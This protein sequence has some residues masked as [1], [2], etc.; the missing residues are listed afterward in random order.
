MLRGALVV[1]A[2]RNCAGPV[3]WFGGPGR[4]PLRCESCRVEKARV[5]D[6]GRRPL[7]AARLC[8][9]CGV[10]FVPARRRTAAYCSV[11]CANRVREAKR[12]TE[13]RLGCEAAPARVSAKLCVACGVG[14]EGLP[15]ARY[16]SESCLKL[17]S[18]CRLYGITPASYRDLWVEQRG[19]CGCCG[20]HFDGSKHGSEMIDH[21]HATGRVRGL[22]C[23]GCNISAGHWESRGEDVE[24]Y[25]ARHELDLR[26]L[27]LR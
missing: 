4:K 25:L 6:R 26:E 19:C 17:A 1:L 2:C 9:G 20:R 13:R 5:R 3:E 15:S 7:V 16:C 12:Q 10:S 24:R 11:V 8:G 22:L 21:D 18:R 27:C 23:W 14:F